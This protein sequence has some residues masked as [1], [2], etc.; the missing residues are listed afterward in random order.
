MK[1]CISG[2]AKIDMHAAVLDVTPED[3]G[4]G[5]DEFVTGSSPTHA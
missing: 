1:D 3:S 4:E 5:G 2:K